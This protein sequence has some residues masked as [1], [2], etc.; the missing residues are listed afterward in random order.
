VGVQPISFFPDESVVPQI[1]SCL[2]W[3]SNKQLLQDLV[4][5]VLVTTKL[6]AVG[7]FH[8]QLSIYYAS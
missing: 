6:E 1:K 3:R 4:S 2:K 8:Y 5:M 7:N